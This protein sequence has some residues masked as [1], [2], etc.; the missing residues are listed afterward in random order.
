MIKDKFM[1]H[2]QHIL[3]QALNQPTSG[4]TSDFMARLF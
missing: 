4:L 1:L 2:L 3:V